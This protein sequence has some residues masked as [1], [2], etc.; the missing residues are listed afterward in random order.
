M[1]ALVIGLGSM[2]KRR[3]RNLIA[4][5]FEQII[6]YDVRNDRRH[7]AA[8]RYGLIPF[9]RI[10]D[11]LAENPDVVVISVPP[12][13][14]ME[15]AFRVAAAGKPMFI[16]ASVVDD[17]MAQLQELIEGTDL[18]VFPSC[19]MRYFP[20]PKRILH[21]V[22]E[23]A[24]GKVLA[25]QY[26][27]GQYLPDWHP[28][29]SITEFYVS[30]RETGGCREIVP[31]EMVWLAQVFGPVVDLDARKAKRSDL[32]V[33]IDDIYMLQVRHADGVLGQL[34]V[35]VLS[36]SAVRAMRITGQD[37]TIEW[38]GVAQRLRIYRVASGEWLEEDLGR[39][40]V[41][42]QYINPEEPYIEEM[43]AF[44]H[45]V[46]TGEAPDYTFE[47]DMALL[48]LLKQAEHADETGRRQVVAIPIKP[49]A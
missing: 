20:G 16:E 29:E 41:E 18:C 31:F 35:D 24:I 13:R 33:D 22:R 28:W 5:G 1:K 45:V 9:D 47:D 21:L 48:A 11:A 42:S 46:E 2:G 43:R 38:D 10:E 27:S 19:T 34:T 49:M 15:V 36:R 26:Q 23:G 32:P 25:W 6:G 3:V 37:G 39:G 7:E 12:D 14:H 44:L 8:E 40:T 4:L 17:G 30:N